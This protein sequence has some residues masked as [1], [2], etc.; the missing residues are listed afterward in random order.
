MDHLTDRQIGAYLDDELS[1]LESTRVDRHLQSCPLCREEY[2]RIR[3]A[4]RRLSRNLELVEMPD[5]LANAEVWPG[6]PVAGA[7][8]TAPHSSG[9]GK[10]RVPRAL[11]TRAA[12]LLLLSVAAA[13]AAAVP[14]SPLRPLAES[15]V[16]SAR[17]LIGGSK[18][19]GP[20][21]GLEVH[22]EDDRLEVRI[23]RPSPET[24]LIVKVVP[25]SVGGVWT[26][27]ARLRSAPGRVHVMEPGVGPVRVHLP[28]TARDARVLSDGN[29][30]AVWSNGELRLRAPIRGSDEEGYR[31]DLGP[32]QP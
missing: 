8:V 11:R 16:D 1:D 17:A 30:V 18:E 31:V 9:W 2:D 19:S 15:L 10:R 21:F 5:E 12:A 14:G 26:S 28:Q 20:G 32:G 4:A 25:D 13:G 3:S 24:T 27:G 6:E 23:V 29:P 7:N 22:P